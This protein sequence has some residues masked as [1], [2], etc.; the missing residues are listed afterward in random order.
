M[1]AMHMMPMEMR[2]VPS[3]EVTGSLRLSRGF[4][5]DST[6]ETPS[7]VH[8]EG[9]SVWE[10]WALYA[11][12]L[13]SERV[14]RMDQLRLCTKSERTGTERGTLMIKPPVLTSQQSLSVTGLPALSRT[15]VASSSLLKT[16]PS[17]AN[18]QSL[19]L[20]CPVCM[21]EMPVSCMIAAP[22]S[23]L[24]II[25]G[26]SPVDS[27]KTNCAVGNRLRSCASITTEQHIFTPFSTASSADTKPA[28]LPLVTKMV[29]K[30]A[31]YEATVMSTK[32]PN[33]TVARR[34]GTEAGRL[35]LPPCTYPANEK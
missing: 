27:A 33:P 4:S 13:P 26:T 23:P 21:F 8:E 22:H 18:P 3:M 12:T 19:V 6:R 16:S 9:G 25:R 24:E 15:H 28:A 7:P 17:S 14:L 1:R 10:N 34:P 29:A 5:M 31:V 11:S 35:A 2:V 30:L 20:Y 32:K